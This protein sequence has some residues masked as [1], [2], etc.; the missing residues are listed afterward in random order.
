MNGAPQVQ[1][2]FEFR[3]LLDG[4]TYRFEPTSDRD[5]APQWRR[6][7]SGLSLA[8][9]EDRGWSIRDHEGT[10]LGLPWNASPKDRSALPPQGIWVSRKGD[11]SYVYEA[12]L[13]YLG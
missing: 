5:H 3:R 13:V 2:T 7:G 12:V 4:L 8:W 1:A 6:P 9:S 10:L 11:R